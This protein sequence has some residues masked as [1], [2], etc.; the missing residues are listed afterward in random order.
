MTSTE[1]L[2]LPPVEAPKHMHRS[3]APLQLPLVAEALASTEEASWGTPVLQKV[4]VQ[5]RLQ[6]WCPPSSIVNS[7]A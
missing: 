6:A 4:A 2:N 7:A 5:V 3:E 1:F